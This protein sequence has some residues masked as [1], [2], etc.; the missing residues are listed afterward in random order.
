[1]K[2]KMNFYAG[3][4][5]L[6]V[7]VLKEM[8]EHIDDYLGHGFSIIEA[9][10]RGKVYDDLHKETVELLKEQLEIPD[11]YSVLF[12]GGGATLQFAM[13][14]Y[15][16]LKEGKS[17]GYIKSGA[18]A[19]KAIKDAKK[20]G[21]VNV[22]FDGEGQNYT[23]LPDPSEVKPDS[24]SSYVHLTSNETIGGLQWRD[25]PDTGGVPLVEIGRAHV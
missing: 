17:A 21:K 19:E 7:E 13:I 14:P 20:I 25:W 16:L 11:N 22:L 18:W 5:V 3:P 12:L 15:N 4:A 8:K 2:R 24:G 10:H 9:S 6:P 1:M 23:T